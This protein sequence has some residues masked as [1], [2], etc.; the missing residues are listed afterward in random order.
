M[1]DARKTISFEVVFLFFWILK[2]AF[3]VGLPSE[4]ELL[5]PSLFFRQQIFHYRAAFGIPKESLGLRFA[6]L[7]FI[8]GSLYKPYRW[9]ILFFPKIGLKL[10]IVGKGV[11]AG[12]CRISEYGGNARALIGGYNGAETLAVHIEL[13]ILGDGGATNGLASADAEGAAVEYMISAHALYKTVSRVVQGKCTTVEL[14]SA[15]GAV[16]KDALCRCKGAL[17]KY[18]LSIS[19]IGS[20]L[21]VYAINEAAGDKGTVFK[22]NVTLAIMG[23]NRLVRTE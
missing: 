1:R 13:T 2:L 14:Y 8:P 9:F 18:E 17:V 4:K 16:S 19:R 11:G 22:H 15:T 20:A 7:S 12:A 3:S 10:R 6:T 23:H 5:S 21:E